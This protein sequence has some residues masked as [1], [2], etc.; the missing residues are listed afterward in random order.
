MLRSVKRER[1]GWWLVPCILAG[2][3][4]AVAQGAAV[5]PEVEVRASASD[6]REMRRNST[7][8]KIIVTREELEA[9]DAASV[10][11]LLSRLP[12]AG[13]F[14]DM[15]SGGRGR[16]PSRNMPQILVDGQSM[17]GGGRNPAAA[18]RL[19]VELIERVEIIRNST[20]EF[21][22]L[23]AGGVV[24][25]VLR[26][27]PNKAVR[28]AKLGLGSTDGEP[29]L[30]VE[31][32]YGEPDGGDF[33][34]LLSGAFS[35][36]PNVGTSGRES[37]SYTAG[38]ASGFLN[39]STRN[40]GRD[41]NLTLSPRFSWKLAEGERLT[42]SPFL[43]A[44]ENSRD[45]FLRRNQNGVSSSEANNDE[46]Q[47]LSGRLSTEWKRTRPG[48]TETT[49]RLMLQGERDDQE[50]QTWRYDGSGA[51]TSNST[52]TTT[53]R[54]QEWMLDLR[55]KQAVFG[56]H[57]LT[58]AI[59]VRDSS[60]NDAQRRSGSVNSFNRADLSERRWVG[61]LQDEWQL[62]EKHVLTPGLRWQMLNTRID[63]TQAGVTERSQRSLDPSLHY[64]WQLTPQ[65]NFRAS[66]AHNMKAPPTR[67]LSPFARAT[68][69]INSSSN[70][71]RG[72]NSALN[73]EKLRSIELGVEHFLP[74]RAGTIGLSV[75]KRE[76]DGYIQRLT[77]LD[78]ASGRWIERPFNVGSA[79]L[80]G[81]VFDYK[82]T[83]GALGL[84]QLTLRGNAAY[85]DV[86]LRDRVAGLG[87]GEGPR[88]SANL[89]MDYEIKDWRLTLG[90][91]FNYVS[92]L[93]RESSATVRQTQGARRQLDLYALHK[94]DRQ[95]SLRFSAQNVT[96]ETRRNSLEE[97]DTSGSL[98][99]S[100]RDW[101][102]GLAT[103]MVTLEARF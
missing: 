34:Y 2:S 30:R 57:L 51:L 92:A 45:S 94:L 54:E 22:V 91:N 102:P 50:R 44:T 81:L 56:D 78:S 14:A 29:S 65:W 9:L 27:V 95:L 21:P 98:V 36:R 59:E 52:E 73:A 83:L 4:P 88:K 32:Q 89:G 25:L 74:N 20:P 64:L 28:S 70:P 26:D 75:F 100:E 80:N 1:R 101:V 87:A 5:M 24:N 38:V 86:T 18:L 63:D 19:P 17:P 58:G 40:T 79:E 71:D 69:G 72:G 6:S 41:N 97:T 68:T 43:T 46:G 48:G 7:A 33:G 77:Q 60:S 55:H 84:P 12:G 8:G 82:T 62:S 96:R 31:G 37:S 15:D 103:Y 99:R 76:I 35:S 90:G 13:M 11:E 49:A 42:V 61:W 53:R 67:D 16:G 3:G 66:V 93:D 39:E 47:R 85:T 23:G 10:A